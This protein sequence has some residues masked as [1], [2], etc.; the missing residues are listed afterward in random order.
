MNRIY[1]TLIQ[2]DIW[3]VSVKEN[4]VLGCMKGTIEYHPLVVTSSDK[5]CA[6]KC[7]GT[8][9]RPRQGC[10]AKCALHR[11]I[12]TWLI[13]DDYHEFVSTTEMDKQQSIWPRR[14]C[15]PQLRVSCAWFRR[16]WMVSEQRQY[17]P[18]IVTQESSPL[19]SQWNGRLS[20]ALPRVTTA[21]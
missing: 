18:L 6:E 13:V 5:I 8:R 14:F 17:C 12:E 1:K 21:P 11:C 20:F 4:V 3:Q 9:E 15:P 16:G 10:P 2:S 7:V 19:I